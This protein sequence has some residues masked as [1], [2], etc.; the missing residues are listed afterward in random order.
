MHKAIAGVEE[1]FVLNVAPV[2]CGDFPDCH[3]RQDK[4]VILIIQIYTYLVMAL[5]IY[6]NAVACCV[7][8]NP[9]RLK[10]QLSSARQ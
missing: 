1:L 6:I 3:I 5:W 10:S 2:I 4:L 9:V 8:K 7:I